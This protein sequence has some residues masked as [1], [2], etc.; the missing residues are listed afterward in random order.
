MR[1]RRVYKDQIISTIVDVTVLTDKAQRV[2]KDQI[3]ST[4][5]DD[6]MER[7][8]VKVYKDQII[9]TIVDCNKWGLCGH[10]VYKDL[11]NVRFKDWRKTNI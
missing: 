3:I 10:F 8:L 6:Q 9:F 1:S 5:V 11:K 4:I 7:T 2:Y